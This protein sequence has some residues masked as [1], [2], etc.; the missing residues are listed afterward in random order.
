MRRLLT[1]AFSASLIGCAS[2][3]PVPEGYTGAT[4]VVADS[5]MSEDGTRARMFVLAEV[6]GNRISSS[7]GASAQASQG[8]GFALSTVFIERKL[9]ARPMKVKL[10]GTHTTAAPIQAMASQMAGTWYSV[11]GI[12]DFRPEPGGSYVVKGELSKTS[13]SVWIEDANTRQIVTEKIIKKQ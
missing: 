2:Y 8:R 12:V 10:L 9:P 7:L 11:E 4:A 1:I 6:D 3:Q 13:S 5:G